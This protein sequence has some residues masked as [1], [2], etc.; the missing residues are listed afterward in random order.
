MFMMVVDLHTSH[1][2][3][4]NIVFISIWLRLYVGILNGFK[5]SEISVKA[6]KFC[7]VGQTIWNV[8]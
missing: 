8:K 4:Q 6:F 7:W 5:T 3:N 1:G 2:N